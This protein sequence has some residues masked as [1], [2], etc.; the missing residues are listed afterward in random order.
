M[1]LRFLYGQRLD[2]SARLLRRGS[3]TAAVIDY[4]SSDE[5]DPALVTAYVQEAVTRHERR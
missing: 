3:T 1:N 2:D 5:V 4:A